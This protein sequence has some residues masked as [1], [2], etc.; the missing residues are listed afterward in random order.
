MKIFFLTIFISLNLYSPFSVI[1]PIIANFFF[2][3]CLFFASSSVKLFS[4]LEKRIVFLS[5]IVFLWVL[6]VSIFNLSFDAYILGKHLRII[7]N[8]ILICIIVSNFKFK[9]NHFF[10]SIGI[11]LFLNVVAVYLQ[12]Y[13]PTTK[14]L[15]AIVSGY[16]KSFFDLRSFGLFSSYDSTGLSICI[17][18]FFFGYL[19]LYNRKN[20]FIFLYVI[21]FISSIYVS[22]F[23][24][25]ISILSF[26]VMMPFIFYKIKGNVSTYVIFLPILIIVGY[27]IYIKSSEI[28]QSSITGDVELNSS[29][30]AS[31]S[32]ILFDDMLFLPENKFSTFFGLAKDPLNSDIG[33]VKIIFMEGIIGLSLILYTYYYIFKKIKRHMRYIDF[34]KNNDFKILYYFFCTLIVLLLIYNCKLLLLYGRGFHDFFIIVA[35]GINKLIKQHNLDNSISIITITNRTN[36][37]D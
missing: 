33:Y 5:M 16:E 23:T 31:S 37:I 26:I 22:R 28:I 24:M 10:Y 11:S 15:F 4:K 2:V 17:S 25:V 12:N 32:D 1:V 36:I 30:G 14:N 9:P 35:F 20:I 34:D 27:S 3:T 19:Y 21:I 7:L 6:L 13:L 18:L 29:Y 8:T